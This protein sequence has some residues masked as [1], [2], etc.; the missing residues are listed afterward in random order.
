MPPARRSDLFALIAGAAFPLGF[1]PFH[2]F[3]LTPLTLAVLFALWSTQGPRHGF[4]TGLL[5]GLGLFGVGASWVFVTLHTFGNMD[6]PLAG[7]A[8]ALFVSVLALFP[9]LAGALQGCFARLHTPLRVVLVAPLAWTLLEWLRGWVFTGLPLLDAGYSQIATPLAGYA[10]WIGIY[11]VSLATAVSAGLLAAWSGRGWRTAWRFGVALVL[12]WVVGFAGGLP[13]WGRDFGKPIRVALV[14]GNI[15][16]EVKWR[17]GYRSAILD[18]YRKLSAA[19]PDADLVIWPEGAVPAYLDELPPNFV[20]ELEQDSRRDHADYLFGVVDRETVN[21]VT[22]YYNA[23]A[24]L[25]SARGV[26]RKHHLVP[27]GEYPPLDPVFRWLLKSMDIP[28]ADFSA[29]P[30]GQ[31]P[32]KVAGQK[33]GMAICYETIFA[34]E[35]AAK[36]PAATMIVNISENAWYGDSLAPHQLLQMARMRAIETDRPVLRVD[37]AGLSAAIDARGHVLAESGQFQQ[38]VL[39]AT[40]QGRTGLTPYVR[41]RNVPVVALLILGLLALFVLN[42]RAA[43]N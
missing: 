3:A 20:H 27:F 37:N 10:P 17:P 24:T 23:A 32:L 41:F 35:T 13:H 18:T 28:M 31:P 38:G 34:T 39:M 43:R 4:R 26:Y 8:T 9:A 5:F 2:L 12:I 7:I 33:A 11:G 42:R 40:V 6:T 14:Q 36:A 25:G 21:G 1:A 19:H 30:V 22:H 29:G 16:I 15:P